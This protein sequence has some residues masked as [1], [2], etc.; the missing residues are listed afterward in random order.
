MS[1]GFLVLNKAQ[2]VST[3]GWNHGMVWPQH[4]NPIIERECAYGSVIN[5]DE[6]PAYSNLNAMEYQHSIVN[7][8]QHYVDPETVA[9]TQAIEWS[10][11]DP[12][13]MILKRMRGVSCQLFQSHLDR[14]CWKVIRKNSNDLFVSFL[15]DVQNVYR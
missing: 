11:L 2:T 14:F 5:S 13:T 3:F 8:Q 4:F 10:W 6:W 1:L 7:H 9:H 15:E 12:K